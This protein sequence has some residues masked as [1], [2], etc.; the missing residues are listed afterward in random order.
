MRR[1]GLQQLWVGLALHLREAGDRASELRRIPRH[2]DH[3]GRRAV[4]GIGQTLKVMLIQPFIKNTN[5]LRCDSEITC[6]WSD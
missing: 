2:L 6:V 1:D 5:T 4:S 3:R